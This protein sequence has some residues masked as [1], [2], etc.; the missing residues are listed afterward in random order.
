MRKDRREVFNDLRKMLNGVDGTVVIWNHLEDA[1]A[2]LPL[3]ALQSLQYRVREALQKSAARAQ[4][5]GS[6]H[7]HSG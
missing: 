5:S 1:L 3:W 2:Q 6:I 4:L 7:D